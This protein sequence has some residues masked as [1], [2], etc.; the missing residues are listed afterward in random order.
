MVLIERSHR[1]LALAVVL[2]ALLV[3]A[4]A[5]AVAAEA[6]GALAVDPI[7]EFAFPTI[8]PELKVGPVDMSIT[9]PVI[10]M[11]LATFIA[12][13]W[14]LLI[15]RNLRLKPD[16]KQTFTEL[17]YEFAH[18]QI[19]GSGLG[20]KTFSRYM[21]LVASLFVFIWLVNL[22]S[23]IPLPV[24]TLHPIDI[25]P[26]EATFEIPG[27]QLYAA[28]SNLNVTLALTL[29]V[30]GISF[31]EGVRHNGPVGYLKSWMP[32]GVPT[33]LVPVVWPLEAIGRLLRIVSL[34]V[35]LFANM[36]AGHLLIAM[37][38]GLIIIMGVTAGAITATVLFAVFAALVTVLLVRGRRN[39]ALFFGMLGA[40]IPLAWLLNGFDLASFPI[41]ALGTVPIAWGFFL[42][43]VCLIATLQAYIFALLSG[44]YIGTEAEPAH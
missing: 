6:G 35:R 13:G 21:P 11:W 37:M 16:G 28:T 40:T 29:M 1:V 32:S 5:P 8:G 24:S 9:K 39:F 36:L 10:Y 3:V 2:A 26:G 33:A 38:L 18:D 12:I 34:S 31:V 17:V 19:A 42:F 22:I 43:E 27:F 15:R 14:A 20:R 30:V 41:L 25:W 44:I 4:P 23:F 7:E